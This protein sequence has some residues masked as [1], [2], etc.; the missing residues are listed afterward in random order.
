MAAGSRVGQ[1]GGQMQS[2]GSLH[3]AAAAWGGG[4]WP[5]GTSSPP[6]HLASQAVPV[7]P[8]EWRG[9]VGCST[10]SPPT[11]AYLL[12]PFVYPWLTIPT[13]T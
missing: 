1:G 6:L 11:H 4:W 3:V 8:T 12:A 13:L 7:Q 9:V 5:L 10:P 2:W